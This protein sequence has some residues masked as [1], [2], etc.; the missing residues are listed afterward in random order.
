MARSPLL[1]YQKLEKKCPNFLG[2]Y[3]G[4]ITYGLNF[5]FKIQFL[6]AS[7]TKKV[8][9]FSLWGIFQE[10]SPALKK[11]LVRS[12]RFLLINWTNLP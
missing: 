4:G 5:S 3:P 1:F 2:K 10:K 12:Q 7:R 8:A 9:D 6:R 11:N